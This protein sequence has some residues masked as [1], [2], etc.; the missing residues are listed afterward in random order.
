MARACSTAR[1][2][3]GRLAW[4]LIAVAAGGCA[5]SPS[6]AALGARFAVRRDCPTCHAP[7]AAAPLSGQLSPR[8]GTESY[9]ANLTP[10]HA[11]GIGDWADLQIVRAMR[12][13]VD[14]VG[15]PLC[16]PMPQFADMTD[17]EARAIVAYLRALPAVAAEV[18]PS[19]CPPLKPRPARDLG[20]A[21]GASEL[22][23][24]DGGGP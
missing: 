11:T 22:H 3:A 10:D 16:P 21:D 4:G 9:G 12:F 8:P 20:A 14:E 15:D 13:G 17:L 23:G 7:S 24:G 19:R 5:A 6:D 18:P 1:A 2:F